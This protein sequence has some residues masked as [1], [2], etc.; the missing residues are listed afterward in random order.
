MLWN[1]LPYNH[2]TP[3]HGQPRA[4]DG[5]S[6]QQSTVSLAPAPCPLPRA[7]CRCGYQRACVCVCVFA[8]PRYLCRGGEALGC[9]CAAIVSPGGSVSRFVVGVPR[10]LRRVHRP[11][12]PAARRTTRLTRPCLLLCLPH[13]GSLLPP[14]LPC[15]L[16][17]ADRVLYPVRCRLRQKQRRHPID[18]VGGQQGAVP[19][20]HRAIRRQLKQP[21]G[22][23][24]VPFVPTADRARPLAWR[25]PLC[26]ITTPTR[27]PY[28]QVQ[29][30]PTR[31]TPPVPPPSPR[32]RC[33]TCICWSP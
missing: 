33:S 31:A 3:P 9:T 11:T 16:L 6:R 14:V 22:C 7:H 24:P 5:A 23:H 18:G 8:Q 17:P 15:P 1:P 12:A 2:T 19:C 13:P 32:S 30:A 21:R 27:A 10:H 26:T 28:T 4:L 20:A 29:P 25:G